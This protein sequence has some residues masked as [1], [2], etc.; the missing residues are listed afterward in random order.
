MT[1]KIDPDLL[2]LKHCIKALEKSSCHR[3][4]V[5]NISF[6]WDRYILHP[7]KENLPKRLK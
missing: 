7:R 1:K 3:M 6:L 4:L 5:A 2:V